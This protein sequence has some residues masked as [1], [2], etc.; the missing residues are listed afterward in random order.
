MLEYLHKQ[1]EDF[2]YFWNTKDRKM[3]LFGFT[4]CC[5]GMLTNSIISIEEFTK[6]TDEID[7]YLEQL[8]VQ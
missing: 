8:K 1:V 6:I 4:S 7:K 5:C 3:W 2:P